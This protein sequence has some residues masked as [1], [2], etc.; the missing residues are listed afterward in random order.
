MITKISQ[1]NY[2]ALNKRILTIKSITTLPNNKVRLFFDY[3]IFRTYLGK[4][5]RFKHNNNI[6]FGIYNETHD[7]NT[8]ITEYYLDCTL[9]DYDTFVVNEKITIFESFIAKGESSLLT[10]QDIKERLIGKPAE[11]N[12]NT[13]KY[14]NKGIDGLLTGIDRE[15]LSRTQNY[16]YAGNIEIYNN[17]VWIDMLNLKISPVGID[18]YNILFIDRVGDNF[19]SLDFIQ[20]NNLGKYMYKIDSSEL[21]NNNLELQTTMKIDDLNNTYITIAGRTE[22][23][24]KW[25]IYVLAK[26][27][28]DIKEPI[29]IQTE[30]I[31]TFNT[32]QSSFLIDGQLEYIDKISQRKLSYNIKY[33]LIPNN[34]NLIDLPGGQYYN[35]SVNSS[36]QNLPT[37]LFTIDKYDTAWTLNIFE[38]PDSNKPNLYCIISEENDIYWGYKNGSN[39]IWDKASLDGHHHDYQTIDVDPEHRW[40]SDTIQQIL[41]DRYLWISHIAKPTF[42]NKP[43]LVQHAYKNTGAAKH[44]ALKNTLTFRYY[45]ADDNS[46]SEFDVELI[47]A[48]QNRAEGATDG[49]AGLLTAE[50]LRIINDVLASKEFVNQNAGIYIGSTINK[51]NLLLANI[52]WISGSNKVGRTPTINDWAVVDSDESSN[53]EQTIYVITNVIG[54]TLTWRKVLSV[55]KVDNTTIELNTSG[56][57][58]IK[59][60]GVTNAKLAQSPTGTIKGNVSG[61]TANVSDIVLSTTIGTS[62][63]DAN[64]PTAKSV[65]TYITN[66]SEPIINPGTTS[67]YWRGDKTWQTLPISDG[68]TIQTTSNKFGV[69]DNSIT[70]TKLA[71]SATGTIKGNVSGSTANIADIALS[72]VVSNTLTNANIPTG[73]AVYDFGVGTFEPIINAGTTT[74]YWRGDK[75]WQTLPTVDASTLELSGTIYQI[76]NNGVTNAKLAQAP[77]GTIKGNIT[78]ALSNVTDILLS[79]TINGTLTNANIPTGKAVYDF[80]NNTSEPIINAGTTSQYWRGDKTWQTLPTVDASTLELSGTTYQI[81]NNGVINAKLAQAPAGTI[82]GNVS[83][84]TANVTDIVLSTAING[85]LTNANIPTG[86]AV[87]DFVNNTSEPII[88]AGTTSQYWR[89]DKTWQ[90]L[91]IYLGDETTI[92]KTG[93]TFNVIDNS[94]TNAK[95]A[96]APARTIKGNVSGSTANVTDIALSTSI[97]TTSTDSQIATAKATQNYIATYVQAAIEGNTGIYAGTTATKANLLANPI[98]WVPGTNIAGHT[99]SLN[100]WAYVLDDES[101]ND[102]KTEYIVSAINAGI[103]TW[104][105]GLDV[106]DNIEPDNITLEVNGSG[107]M[108]IKNNGITNAKLA[109][110]PTMTLKGNI[111]GATANISDVS[112]I[113]SITAASTDIQI[114]TA[115][116]VF[117]IVQTQISGNSEPIINPGT[118]TQYWRG[119]KTWQTLPTADAA[120]LELSGTNYRIKDNGVTNAKLAQAPAGTIK[121]NI[122]AATANV[123]DIALSTSITSTSTNAQVPTAL[124]VYNFVNGSYEAKITAGTTSQYLRGDK[125]W[126]TLPTVDASTLEL[127][128]TNYRIKDNGVTNAKL[129]Q[130]P[131]GTIKGNVSG[132][133]ANVTDITLSTS[134]T[135]TS[136]NAQVPTAKAIYDFVNGSYEAKITAGTTSQYWRGDKTWQT[137]PTVDASTLELSGTNY[138]IKNNG[139]TNA[140]L[141]Q[142][143]AGTIKGN[144]SG[145]TANVTDIALSTSITSTSTNA[146]VPTAKAIYDF[147]NGD[148]EAK[149]TAGTTSQY[150]RGDKTWQTLPTAEVVTADGSTLQKVSS[151]FSIKDNGVTNAKLAQAPAGTIKGNVSGSTANV[152]DITLS[153]S[154]TSTS[155]NAQVSTAKAIYDF[156]NGGYEAKITAGTTSQYWRGDKTWQTLPTVDA[157][158]LELSGTNYRIKDNGVTNAKLAQAPAG[159][160]KGNIAAATA[161][162]TDIALS[163]SITSTS[164]NA[165]V[166]TAKAIYD[167]VN[168]GYEAKITAGTTSQYWRGD[169]TWQTLPTAEVVTADG[170]TLQK[171]SSVFSIKDNGVTNDK[172][173]QASAMTVLGN[174]TTLTSNITNINIVRSVSSVSMHNNIPTT[175]SVYD[176]IIANQRPEW[177][178][179]QAEYD[180]L[181]MY[182]LGTLY[183]I[184]E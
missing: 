81:K 161:N 159:T 122:T 6:Y 22:Y 120:T 108:A 141:A 65:V 124:S 178:G 139:V 123:T 31:L 21:I 39:I 94:I 72:T 170:S 43:S 23:N 125:T 172:L 78:A 150:W 19:I 129:A 93:L 181:S 58:G 133:T 8:N 84:S 119:D 36:F 113:T 56:L 132:S 145:A 174:I 163:T 153:T 88:N 30:N 149:I 59:N 11:F 128:G 83:G 64:I 134:I 80:V 87:Y 15:K 117:S 75:T 5:I 17:T 71:Q 10:I 28:E 85:T 95:L 4:P 29:N 50:T 158:T 109:Q 47:G 155:T 164:T 46:T 38:N 44:T 140:K 20:E 147:V 77:A 25:D 32:I 63:T 162:V 121:G 54:T 27:I 151:V 35:N 76:K 7:I 97:S 3:T 148:Y 24:S 90:T 2:A 37:E 79:T 157:S 142:A 105:K 180:A 70:N 62:S 13:L 177:F 96:Q 67:Q 115:K 82:K 138:Q 184:Y 92:H 89:G 57:I 118:T 165:Q 160:I 101:N 106:P 169:K 66:T 183:Y 176:A 182:D 49:K 154:I 146:Q 86:K 179:T 175:K 34:S 137:L 41:D 167:F 91:P 166:P 52:A 112:V 143:P 69:I 171:V 9:A 16:Y 12:P 14:E 68:I 135:S 100:D 152:T 73:K 116:A 60:N 61:A 74:Q 126:Q 18:N 144:V 102:A 110:A 131:A 103:P 98:V 51:A 111:T 173:A 26:N 45:N 168:G 48:T 107:N 53:S 114:P 99:I 130:A 40:F 42:S 136:T 127:S 33:E 156:V 104:T 55:Q 1:V